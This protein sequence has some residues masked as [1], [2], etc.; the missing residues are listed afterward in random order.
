MLEMPVYVGPVAKKSGRKL[1]EMNRQ[2][3]EDAEGFY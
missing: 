1:Q 3:G 2:E